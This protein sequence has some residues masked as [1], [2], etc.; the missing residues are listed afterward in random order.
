M[1]KGIPMGKATGTPEFDSVGWAHPERWN[2]WTGCTRCSP[3]CKNCYTFGLYNRQHGRFKAG[4][5][6]RGKYAEADHSVVVFH[7]EELTVP[8]SW[9]DPRRVFAGS[10]CDPFHEDARLRDIQ[11]FFAVMNSNLCHQFVVLTRR[12]NRLADI[13]G[14]LTF[15]PN[16]WMCVSVENNDYVHRIDL[17]RSIDAPVKGVSFEPLIGACPDAD[18]T[19]IH[20]AVVGSDTC[21][22]HPTLARPM[23][24]DWASEIRDKCK[25][26]GT[27]FWYKGNGVSNRKKKRTLDGRVHVEMPNDDLPIYRLKATA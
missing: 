17:L 23:D 22:P 27:A 19:G 4:I 12:A 16:I 26:A 20:W 6:K 21:P 2:C 25:A 10:M 3:G 15:T 9:R 5:D 14:A 13:A 7:P 1:K 11:A 24:E 18:L 8:Y